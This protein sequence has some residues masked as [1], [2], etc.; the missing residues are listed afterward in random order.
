[1]VQFLKWFK[2]RKFT[3]KKKKKKKKKNFKKL[4]QE[5]IEKYKE[6]YLQKEIELKFLRKQLKEK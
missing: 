3:K 1:M 6:I 2:N 5:K 4:S